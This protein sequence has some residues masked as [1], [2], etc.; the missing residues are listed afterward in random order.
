MTDIEIDIDVSN[1]TALAGSAMKEGLEDGLQDAGE[2][3][4]E[5]GEDK[6]KDSVLSADRVWRG[7]LKEGFRSE[8]RDTGDFYS[9][10][11]QVINDAP[12]ARINEEGRDPG[13]APA[14]Q[15]II[16]W[17]DDKVVGS[18]S[19]SLPRVTDTQYNTENWNPQLRA[20]AAN[21]SPGTVIT[22]FAV[23]EGLEDSGYPGIGFMETTEAYLEGIG[24]AVVKQKVEKHINRELR[25]AGLQ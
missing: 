13:S 9:W 6:G 14:V 21:Y 7:T 25:K 15:D 3:L 8:E 5:E 18:A 19:G 17:V 10:N 11:G 23:K 12:H 2:W 20:L 1:N 22:A 24:P 16:A 4:L